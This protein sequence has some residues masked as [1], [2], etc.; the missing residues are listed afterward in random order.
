MRLLAWLS[1]PMWVCPAM[2]RANRMSG[3]S[4][5]EPVSQG[6][7]TGS[8]KMWIGIT[9]LVVVFMILVIVVAVIVETR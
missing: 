7:P 5:N 1:H 8:S 9:M 6:P 2:R 3:V 4:D